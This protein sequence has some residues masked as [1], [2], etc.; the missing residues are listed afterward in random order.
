[1]TRIATI[2][3]LASLCLGGCS[4]TETETPQQAL[5]AIIDL[6]EAR[7]FDLLIRTRYAEIDK[8]DGENQIQQLVDRFAKRFAS[9]TSLRE[10]VNTYRKALK[11]QPVLSEKGTIA[12][13]RLE[14]GFI[15]LSLQKNETWGFHL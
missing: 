14:T 12:T 7:D 1:M 4:S 3:I 6:Y 8:A 11:I 10:A 9:D 5:Q 15:K 2:V 13:F